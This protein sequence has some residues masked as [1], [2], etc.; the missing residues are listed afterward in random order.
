MKT[1]LYVAASSRQVGSHSRDLAHFFID[2]FVKSKKTLQI[3]NR[4][5][6]SS[7]VEHITDGTIV[8]FYTPENQR[9]IQNNQDLA[10]SDT[11]I[12]E[13]KVADILLISTPMYNFSIPSVLKAWIDQI[14][15]IGETFNENFEGLIE[16]KQAYVI[17]AC[18]ASMEKMQNMDYMTPYLNFILSFIGFKKIK[19]FHLEGTTTDEGLFKQSQLNAQNQILKLGEIQ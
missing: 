5:L 13:L 18:G 3:L 19:F 7:T 8:G 4:D 11:L 16:N 17:T 9:S 15:R 1:L 12:Q 10:L 2:K 6:V 14:T